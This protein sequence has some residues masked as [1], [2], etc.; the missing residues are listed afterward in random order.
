MV[1]TRLPLVHTL[2]LV[3]KKLGLY[4]RRTVVIYFRGT[5]SYLAMTKKAW[6]EGTVLCRILRGSI[7]KIT[8][9]RYP[10]FDGSIVGGHFMAYYGESNVIFMIIDSKEMHLTYFNLDLWFF[11]TYLRLIGSHFS[12]R[13]F[14]T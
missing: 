13:S 1:T 11:N 2:A 5:F 7:P 9:S 14:L 6:D 12:V 10:V 4:V 3:R 8:T